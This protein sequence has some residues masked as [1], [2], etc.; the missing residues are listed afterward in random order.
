M[1][2]RSLLMDLILCA[3]EAPQRLYCGAGNPRIRTLELASKYS[4][5]KRARSVYP[6]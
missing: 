1:E 4:T 3:T 5:H 2:T 6:R